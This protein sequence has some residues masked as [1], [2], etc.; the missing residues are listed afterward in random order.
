MGGVEAARPCPC[1]G[2]IYEL[3]LVNDKKRP[4]TQDLGAWMKLR[5]KE[6]ISRFGGKPAGQAEFGRMSSYRGLL[7]SLSLPP[8][9]RIFAAPT[10]SLRSVFS[11]A[12]P[13]YGYGY[14]PRT[15]TDAQQRTRAAAPGRSLPACLL[16]CRPCPWR[17]AWRGIPARCSSRWYLAGALK[18]LQIEE[19][20]HTVAHRPCEL[21]VDR[22]DRSQLRP[23][24]VQA[25]ERA[26]PHKKAVIDVAAVH[27]KAVSITR[28]YRVNQLLQVDMR[29]L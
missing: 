21:Q 5:T 13:S 26:G 1:V 4:Q 7:L 2:D 3:P 16:A 12:G 18:Y 17:H 14:G 29:N 28:Q 23:Q 20:G 6:S 27:R 25:L 9:T 22:V 11:L 19:N 15:G 24:R 8:G 10:G